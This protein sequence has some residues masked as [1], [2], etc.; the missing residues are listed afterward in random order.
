[1]IL[2]MGVAVRVSVPSSWM[3][4]SAGTP[5]AAQSLVALC[6]TLEQAPSKYSPPGVAI[7]NV[8]AAGYA[9]SASLVLK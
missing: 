4:E 7:P 3:A 8:A 6:R 9:G 1:M 5:A 2:A